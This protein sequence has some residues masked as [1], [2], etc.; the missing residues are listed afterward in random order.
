MKHIVGVTRYKELDVGMLGEPFV[1]DHE[2]ELFPFVQPFAHIH[3]PL[4]G[5]GAALVF[6]AD[7]VSDASVSEIVVGSIEVIGVHVYGLDCVK[8][9]AVDLRVL[10]YPVEYR[11]V[12]KTVLIFCFHNNSLFTRFFAPLTA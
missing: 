5:G 4:D 7:P 1:I 6:L 9:H 12:F 3:I 8:A 10:D 2:V 11:R